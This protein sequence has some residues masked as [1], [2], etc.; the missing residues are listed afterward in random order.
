MSFAAAE[1]AGVAGLAER[2][3]TNEAARGA[4]DGAAEPDFGNSEARVIFGNDDSSFELV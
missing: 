4:F 1:G 3:G 2:G